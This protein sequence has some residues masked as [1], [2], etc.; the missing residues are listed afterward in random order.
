MTEALPVIRPPITMAPNVPPPITRRHSARLVVD[1]TTDDKLMSV[2]KFH[3]YPYWTFNGGVPGPFIRA[4][5]GDVLEMNYTNKDSSGMGHNIDLHAVTGPGGGAPCL[6]AEQDETKTGM[7]KLLAPGLFIY[8]C[9]AAP[10]PQH[11]QNGMFGLILVEPEE[12]LPAVDR[13][14]YVMQHEIYA[15]ESEE[16]SSILE[17][18]YESGL[19]ENP[20]YVLFN[21]KEGALTEKPLIAQQGERIRI[22]FGNAGPN[23]SSSFHVIGMIFDKLYRDADV[24]S[25]PARCVQ[26]TQVPAGGATIVEFDGAVPGNY[27]L[28]DHSI[29]RIDKG[30]VGFLKVKGQPRPDIYDSKAMPA[31]CPDCKLH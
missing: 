23:L 17:P 19:A 16:D 14:F 25:P 9:A 1:F 8:H 29:F 2:S 4:R 28:V 12:G 26:T 24:I 7:F 13:E 10:V 21:G 31:N 27:T 11:I 30:A 20:L 18:D 5:V 15:T 3:K 6:F 22:F